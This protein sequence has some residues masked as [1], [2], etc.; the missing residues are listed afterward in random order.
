MDFQYQDL[1]N[2]ATMVKT[3]DGRQIPVAMSQ[4]QMNN[5]IGVQPVKF[6]S[7]VPSPTYAPPPIPTLEPEP[8]VTPEASVSPMAGGFGGMGGFGIQPAYAATPSRAE[9]QNALVQPPVV[10]QQQ[11]AVLQQSPSVP[12]YF[13]GDDRSE[14]FVTPS[15]EPTQRPLTRAEELS[16]M[17]PRYAAVST[18]KE[19]NKYVS[20]MKAQAEAEAKGYEL[21]QMAM[22][23]QQAEIER[24]KQLDLA[25]QERAQAEIAKAQDR[26]EKMYSEVESFEFESPELLGKTAG[27]RVMSALAIGLGAIGAAMTGQSRNAALEILTKNVDDQV[28]QQKAQLGKKMQGKA[29]AG[30]LLQRAMD[31]YESLPQAEAA[32]RLAIFQKTAQEIEKIKMQTS[33]NVVRANAE[34]M[35]AEVALKAQEQKAA[36][37]AAAVGKMQESFINKLGDERVAENELIDMVRKDDQIKSHLATQQSFARVNSAKPDAAGDLSLIFAY[38]KMLD[39]GSVVREGEFANAQ[40]AAGVPEKIRNLFNKAARGERLGDDQ[41]QAFKSQAEAIYKESAALAAPRVKFYTDIA[42]RRGLDPRVIVDPTMVPMKQI[43]GFRKA[44]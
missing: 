36:M 6:E 37:Q 32:T 38:M 10:N 25:K 18:D 14:E 20:A 21:Q 31:R 35:G 42:Q 40:N 43:D 15:W 11:P 34:V 8:T 7:T 30:N 9:Q 28:A 13:P 41:R 16:A 1:G 4:E 23:E 3:P 29:E 27:T 19:R 24:Q 17:M 39:P 22:V 26:F 12:V 5:L 44:K 33:S 2:G